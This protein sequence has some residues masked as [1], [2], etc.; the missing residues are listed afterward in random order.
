MK[1]Q[2][3][4]EWQGSQVGEVAE[5]APFMTND[6]INRKIVKPYIDESK[7]DAQIKDLQTEVAGLKRKLA[8]EVRS[9]PVDKQVKKRAVKTK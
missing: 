1:V 3:L 8:K 6:L 7:K 9:A 2:F 4:T 5:F